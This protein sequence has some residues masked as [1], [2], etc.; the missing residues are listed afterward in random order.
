MRHDQ[1]GG[2]AELDG[3]VAVGHGIQ[4]IAADLV[5]VQAACHAFAVDGIGSTRQRSSA[6][7][8]AVRAAAAIDQAFGI[9]AKHFGIGQQMVAKGNRLGYLQ[10]GEARQ[11]GVGVLQGQGGQASTQLAQQV[12][13][14]ID[15]VAQPQA[16]VGGDLVVARTPGVQTLACVAD[17]FNQT[18]FDVQVHVFQVQR[19][20]ELAILDF[21]QNPGHAA[22]DVAQVCGADYADRRQHV[23]VSQRALDIELGHA[24]IEIDRCGIAFHQIR[25]RLGE[26]GR[27]GLGFIIE[28]IV[29]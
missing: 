7:R 20:V 26:A 19:P 29:G 18:F 14:Q 16:D 6:Q 21:L 22:L 23:G 8:Q 13:R 11:D 24:L 9:A 12:D 28:L 10:V 1:G 27:P 15:L 5:E 3:E 4:R 2:G 17:E 25:D